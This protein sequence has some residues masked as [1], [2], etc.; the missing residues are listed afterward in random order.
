LSGS[1]ALMLE[2]LNHAMFAAQLN[3]TFEVTIGSTTVPFTLIEARELGRQE[4]RPAALGRRESFSLVFRAP[5]GTKAEQSIYDVKN[6]SL[7]T[8][9]IFLVPIGSDEAG[10]RYEAIFN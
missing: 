8:F 3:G 1:T 10:P 9:G 6:A 5:R 7:G 4:N 2:Q